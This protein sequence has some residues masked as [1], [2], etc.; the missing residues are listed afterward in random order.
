M[1]A[2]APLPL[3]SHT[4]ADAIVAWRHGAPISRRRMLGDI[5]R[6]AAALPAGRH[7]LNVCS[8]RYHFA[9]GLAA[10]VLAG[11]ISLLP[12]TLTESVVRQ[13]LVDAPDTVL[14][15]EADAPALLPDTL[16]RL[17]YPQGERHDGP[18]QV[19]L[20]DAGQLA[21]RVFT[22]G[23]TGLPQPHGKSWGRLVRN[24]RTGARALGLDDG[25]NFALLGTVPPQHMYGLESTVLLALHG[26]GALVAERPFHPAEI[27]AALA[28][29]PA[30]RVLVSTPFHLR[31]LLAA[32]TELPTLARVL[33]ATSPL[34]RTLAAAIEAHCATRLSEIYG[35]TESGQVAVRDSAREEHWTLMPG[36]ELQQRDGRGWVSGG[37]IEAPVPLGD[38]I[39]PLDSRHFMLGARDEDMVNIAGKRTSLAYLNHQLL[40][41]AG[42]VDGAFYMPD[43]TA[44]DAAQHGITRL[45]AF[46]VAPTLGREALL[47][48]LR[49]A[50][51]PVFLP[52]PL[53]HLAT[54]P[55]N[56]TGKL[57][58]AACEALLAAH[59]GSAP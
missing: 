49:A 25:R 32:G 17:I 20:I 6:V 9:V 46:V 27:A 55:R 26:G 43:A 19:P 59:R 12:S 42:V 28:A 41:I 56:A 34:E 16:P 11:R 58:R 51:D 40:A 24:A 5:E 18:A 38:A 8:D 37:H 15:S 47:H 7:L 31:T 39:T 35:S 10:G 14:L 29:L 33:S 50:I 44:D 54:L 1:S 4:E 53:I 57:P 21:A 23:S 22:S 13:L 36:I 48:A 45:A 2:D 52:R 30:P 3:L